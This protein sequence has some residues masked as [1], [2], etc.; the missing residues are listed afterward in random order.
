MSDEN[1]KIKV[2]KIPNSKNYYVTSTGDVYRVT[3]LKQHKNRKGYLRVRLSGSQKSRG[4][5]MENV[6]RIVA[7]AFAEELP[8]NFD[9]L[10]VNHK[11]KDRTNNDVEN[12]EI[13]TAIENCKHRDTYKKVI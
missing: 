9:D 2:A 4:R 13:V 10:Q 3:K 12:L 11:D 5:Q 1:K 8:P 7:E 6:H